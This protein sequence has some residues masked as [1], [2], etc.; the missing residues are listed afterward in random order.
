MCELE[1]TG[2]ILLLEIMLLEE[3][4]YFKENIDWLFGKEINIS[5]KVQDVR[6][7]LSLSNLKGRVTERLTNLPSVG[8]LP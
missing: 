3:K 4:I 7:S 2:S 5:L 8:S 6:F 1:Y